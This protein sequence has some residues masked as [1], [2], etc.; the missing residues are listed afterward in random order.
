[1]KHVN[2]F[3]I[4]WILLV[5]SIFLHVFSFFYTFDIIS[6]SDTTLIYLIRFILLFALI[7]YS[8]MICL[9]G[10]Y[11]SIFILIPV[12]MLVILPIISIFELFKVYPDLQMIMIKQQLMAQFILWIEFSVI[13]LIMISK[14]MN[15]NI[16]IILTVVIM[17]YTIVVGTFQALEL[18]QVAILDTFQDI[19]TLILG[20]IISQVSK[21]LIYTALVVHLIE[22]K[23][24]SSEEL[25]I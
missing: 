22:E 16:A 19:E 4:I 11:P 7:L 18:Y 21:L 25:M 24:K 15:Q 9:R 2:R 17:I 10:K 13:S 3:T 23:R 6:I 5:V 1:M 8:L 14:K 20:Q 12:G